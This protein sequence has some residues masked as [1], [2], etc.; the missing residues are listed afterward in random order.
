MKKLTAKQT[1]FCL[2]YL[3]GLN[4]KQ[5]ALRSG[6][7][8]KTARSVGA[9]NLTK[10][11]IAQRIAELKKQRNERVLI[12][13]DDIVMELQKIAFSSAA[14]LHID[15]NEL[16]SWDDLDDGQKA[17]IASL[18]V[19]ESKGVDWSKTVTEIKLHDKLKALDMLSRHLGIYEKDN[20]QKQVPV[21]NL[22]LI[23]STPRI[24]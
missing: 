14:D 8:K 7:S 15:W 5:A 24:G 23:D 2:E 13:A 3:V 10:P 12:Q 4:A 20:Q 19:T 22:N 11:D 16:K 9:E 18:K 6:Y 17:V 21:I 1:R